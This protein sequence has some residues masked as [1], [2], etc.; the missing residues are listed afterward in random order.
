MQLFDRFYK[1]GNEGG[2]FSHI[3]PVTLDPR[4]ES[5]GPNRA[6][7]NWNSVGDHAPAYL[8]NLYLAT[9][10]ERY[11]DFLADT[12]TRSA[13]HF[14]DYEHSPFVQEQFFEDWTPRQDLGLAAE[15]RG[16]RP[17]PQDRLEPDADP[18]RPADAE[19]RA[20]GPQ[21]RG[22]HA[23]RRQRP[24]ARRLV[25]RGGAA[26]CSPARRCTASSGTTARRGGSRSRRSWPT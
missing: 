26:R 18:P 17:Q 14:P 7:K 20:P 23:G 3:D 13:E 21:D 1:D 16:R 15:P 24:A 10:E 5:L 19:V 2:Y 25:R 22:A 8:I 9:G 12:A 4:A 6:R 11:A